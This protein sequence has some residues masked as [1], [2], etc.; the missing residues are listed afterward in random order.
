MLARVCGQHHPLAVRKVSL[1][2]YFVCYAIAVVV[3]AAIDITWLT[4]VGGQLYK[5]TLGDILVPNIRMAPAIAFYL[6]YPVGLIFFAVDPAWKNGSIITAVTHGALFGLFTYGT[7]ELT[8]FA[9]LRNWTLEITAIDMTYGAMAS[10]GVAAIAF[11]LTPT[12]ARWF[13]A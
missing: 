3:F 11:L 4:V 7:Y 12:I 8:N 10:A 13:G 9:T 1:F 2:V 6:L 5:Q